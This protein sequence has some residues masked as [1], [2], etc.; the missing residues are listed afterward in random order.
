MESRT[1]LLTPDTSLVRK[2]SSPAWYYTA[3]RMIGWPVIYFFSWAKLINN[4]WDA[5]SR[6][7]CVNRPGQKHHEGVNDS[8]ILSNLWRESKNQVITYASIDVHAWDLDQSKITDIGVS[9]WDSNTIEQ[10]DIV[11]YHWQIK[12]NTALKNK[13]IPN[14]PDIFT[15]EG[16][17]LIDN[18]QVAPILDDIF[19]HLVAEGQKLAIVGHGIQQTIDV[20]KHHWQP[21]DSA[22][23]LDTQRI[24]KIQQQQSQQVTLEEALSTTSGLV[25]DEHLLHNVGNK[26]RYTLNLLQAQGTLSRKPQRKAREGYHD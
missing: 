25:Y 12:D 2:L 24:W 16:T 19:E 11:S 18:N 17:K 14:N 4:I 5:S 8:E 26:A 13:C 7:V 22:I 9:T 15:F 23:L 21:P 6:I 3:L 1:S 20:L 10:S